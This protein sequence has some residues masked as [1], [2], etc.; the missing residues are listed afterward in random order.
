MF[1]LSVLSSRLARKVVACLL[2]MLASLYWAAP[3]EVFVS[4]LLQKYF[5]ERIVGNEV[6]V[7]VMMRP[8]MNRATTS[9]HRNK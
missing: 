4:I 7:E 1:A 3:L 2:G 9:Q 5:V 8:G 6:K